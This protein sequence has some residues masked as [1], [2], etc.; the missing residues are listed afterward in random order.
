MTFYLRSFMSFFYTLIGIAIFGFFLI[1]MQYSPVLAIFLLFFLFFLND[2]DKEKTRK[3]TRT[4]DDNQ[5]NTSSDRE[6]ESIKKVPKDMYAEYKSYLLSK[7]WQIDRTR[8]LERDNYTCQ[9]CMSTSNLQVHHSDY[10]GIYEDFN[11]KD[12]NTVTLCKYCHD[13]E[14]SH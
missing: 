9:H 13:L 8:I 2:R 7:R 11:F 4:T 10:A 3:D 1:L 12:E 6:M 5:Y 14:H